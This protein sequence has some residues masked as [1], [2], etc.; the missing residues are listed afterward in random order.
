MG[1][2]IDYQKILETLLFFPFKSFCGLFTP[3]SGVNIWAWSIF[4]FILFIILS[5]IVMYLFRVENWP[6]VLLREVK[7]FVKLIILG[8]SIIILN[9]II[10]APLLGQFIVEQ[11]RLYYLTTSVIVSLI[12]ETF[13]VHVF[14]GYKMSDIYR[15]RGWVRLILFILR[16]F[17]I[18]IIAYNNLFYLLYLLNHTIF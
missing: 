5:F 7:D 9:I 13:C 1:E 3:F 12:N 14:I 18:L 16:N 11:Y 8:I 2:K 4:V 17:F 10:I 6:K 15:K